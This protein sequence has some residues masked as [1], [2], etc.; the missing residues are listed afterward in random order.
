MEQR[1]RWS[2]GQALPAPSSG[3]AAGRS[4]QPLVTDVALELERRCVR[5][6]ERPVTTRVWLFEDC[7]QTLFRW[8]IMDLP[9]VDVLQTGVQHQRAQKTEEDHQCPEVLG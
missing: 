5:T 1:A 2:I 8:T 6:E 4:R 9:V 3:S 7:V